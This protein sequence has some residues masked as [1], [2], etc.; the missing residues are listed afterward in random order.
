M[1]QVVWADPPPIKAPHDNAWE[2]RDVVPIAFFPDDLPRLELDPFWTPPRLRWA[3]RHARKQRFSR[4]DYS[5]A[6]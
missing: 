6:R 3:I 5:V 4:K 2:H 1:T